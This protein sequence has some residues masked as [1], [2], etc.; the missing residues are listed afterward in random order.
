VVVV[1]GGG[2][3]G[4]VGVPGPVHFLFEMIENKGS[5]Y[6]DVA[7]ANARFL[8]SIFLPYI[9]YILRLIFKMS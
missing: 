8:K 1:A 2:S 5:I 3:G 7:T 6:K 4:G 9:C